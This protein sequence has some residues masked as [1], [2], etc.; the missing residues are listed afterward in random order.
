MTCPHTGVDKADSSLVKPTTQWINVNHPLSETMIVFVFR[1]VFERCTKRLSGTRVVESIFNQPVPLCVR[2]PITRVQYYR[3]RWNPMC[4]GP[5]TIRE[6]FV[7]DGNLLTITLAIDISDQLCS[8]SRPTRALNR[9][10]AARHRRDSQVRGICRR[11]ENEIP[12][13][14]RVR[15][16]RVRVCED[17]SAGAHNYTY[18]LTCHLPTYLPI[19]LLTYQ[20]YMP[21][22]HG[23]A[24]G[25]PVRHTSAGV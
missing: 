7:V 8:D 18:L 16:V 17:K 25:L 9:T 20:L 2:V 6:H 19:Y 23:W 1:T 3:L 5:S 12:R 4:N 13:L 11:F 14:S 10:N 21:E 15:Y 24:G 22:T